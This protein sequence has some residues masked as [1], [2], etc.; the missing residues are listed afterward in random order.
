MSVL[1]SLHSRDIHSNPTT[2]DNMVIFPNLE[3]LILVGVAH[4]QPDSEGGLDLQ[5]LGWI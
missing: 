5:E 2:Q 4:K 1:K 3:V